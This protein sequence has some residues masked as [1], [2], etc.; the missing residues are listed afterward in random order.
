MRPNLTTLQRYEAIETGYHSARW[1][2]PIIYELSRQGA[3]N[4]VLPAI[5]DQIAEKTRDVL[6]RIPASLRR[7]RPPHLPELAEPEITR[8]F[9]RLSQQTFGYDSGVSMGLGTSTMKYSPKI[10][11]QLSRLPTL[12]ALHPLQPEATVQGILE[13]MYELRSW[14]C[15]LSGMDEFS[16]QP[17]SGAHAVFT[18]ACIIRKYHQSRGDLKRREVITSAVSHP[19]NAGCP[20]AAGFKI[21]TL[22]PEKDTGEI[23]PEAMKAAVS[24]QT[25]AMMITAPYDTGVFDRHLPDYVKMVHDAGGL[26]CLDQANFNGIMTKVRAGDVGADLMHFNLHKSFSTPHGSSGPGSGVVGVREHLKR[27]LPVPMVEYD[28]SQYHLN[29]D[30]PES[31]GKVGSFYGAAANA[32]KAYAWI[33]AMGEDGLREAADWAVINN[34]YLIK[35]LLEVRGVEVSW[36]HRR[37]L[38]EARFSLQRLREETGIGSADFKQRIADYGVQ[39]CFES[40]EPRIIPE[41]ITP[42]PTESASREDI[43]RFVEVFRRVSDEA[44]ADPDII[45]TAPH[46]CAVHRINPEPLSDPSRPVVTWRA[47]QK[48]RK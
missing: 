26:V 28:G 3:R 32:V 39:T 27:F 48:Q 33:L 14:L 37:K 5:E 8:H 19:S 41:P 23:S 4:N 18:N 12:A 36:P 6:S 9:L 21:L 46:R 7:L 47:Y 16:F 2:E 45:R 10:D 44:Y 24:E 17:R 30:V 20:A 22:Y 11:D 29:Y 1:H 31:I 35:K 40:H 25:A 13:I 34:N 42:E 38:Q 43:E 15:E